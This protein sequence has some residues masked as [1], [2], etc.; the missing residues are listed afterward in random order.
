MRGSRTGKTSGT[1]LSIKELRQN[2]R[3]GI[4][5]LQERVGVPLQSGIS[6]QPVVQQAMNENGQKIFEIFW[7]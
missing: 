5:E 2:L 1:T 7:Q 4:T 3:R 6:I